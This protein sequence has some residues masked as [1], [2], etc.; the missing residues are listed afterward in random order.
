MPNKTWTWV[1]CEMNIILYGAGFSGKKAINRIKDKYKEIR[2]LGFAD[3]SRIGEFE[4]VPIISLDEIEINIRKQIAIVITIATLKYVMEVCEE[5][6]KKGFDHIYYYLRKNYCMGTDFFKNECIRLD[7]IDKKTLPYVEMHLADCCNLNCRGCT[8]FSAIFE[9]K[10]PDFGKRIEAVRIIS[11]LFSNVLQISLL[12]GEP[13]LNPNLNEYVME[14]RNIFPNTELQIVTNGLLLLSI[15]EEIL[16][17]IASNHVT[18]SISEYEPTHRMIARIC[19]RLENYGIDYSIRDYDKKNKFG[20]PLS[21]KADSI[22]PH[23]CL[24]DGCT[25]IHDGKIARCPTLMF[26]DRF[27]EYFH[28]KLPNEGIYELTEVTDSAELL[29]SLNRPV[30]LCRHCISYEIEWERCGMNIEVSDFALNE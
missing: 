10:L 27:N 18:V 19:Q 13:L 9:K 25:V 14:I 6:K 2:I 29:N 30:P 20:M 7:N 4:N 24:S 12:G 1:R 15:S 5:L 3:S 26:I 23:K 16:K 22:Y 11:Q 8:H 28:T 17:K 21:L